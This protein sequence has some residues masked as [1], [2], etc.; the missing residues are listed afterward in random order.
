MIVPSLF[1]I[2]ASALFLSLAS[3]CEWVILPRLPKSCHCDE[4]NQG[5]ECKAC[6]RTQRIG[7]R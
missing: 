6:T 1:E 5:R 4:V 2:L 7:A 3:V